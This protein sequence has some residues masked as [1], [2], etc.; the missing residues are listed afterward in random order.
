MVLGAGVGVFATTVNVAE[1]EPPDSSVAVTVYVPK[2]TDGIAN[3]VF[4]LPYAAGYA[5]ATCV[6]PNLTITWEPNP[7]P[8]IEAYEPAGP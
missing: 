3:P 1:A 7:I 5:L 4:I 2:D 8:I 6:E